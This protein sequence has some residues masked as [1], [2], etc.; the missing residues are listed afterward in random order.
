MVVGVV[1]GVAVFVSG[2]LEGRG[3][4]LYGFKRVEVLFELCGGG[5]E[6]LER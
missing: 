6:L 2:W 4:R 1:V 3:W 5:R